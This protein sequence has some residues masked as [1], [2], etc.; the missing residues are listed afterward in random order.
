MRTWILMGIL[1]MCQ[2]IRPDMGYS[3]FLGSVMVVMLVVGAIM[4]AVEFKHR[5][6]G[7]N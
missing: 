5:I 6:F 1:F 4:D 2:T 7:D 3:V